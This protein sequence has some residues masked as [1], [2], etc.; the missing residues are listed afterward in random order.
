MSKRK[1]KKES[2]INN[3][4]NNSVFQKH[5]LATFSK[6]NEKF[7]M[8]LRTTFCL[9]QSGSKLTSTSAAGHAVI[10]CRLSVQAL[11]TGRD[12]RGWVWGLGKGEWGGV[13][14][15]IGVALRDGRMINS[16][17]FLQS[18]QCPA[19]SSSTVADLPNQYF[20]IVWQKKLKTDFIK[21]WDR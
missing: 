7:W 6:E 17:K 2:P 21:I 8:L 19:S 11:W 5:R 12:D 14:L 1:N 20:H 13:R 18:D 3:W 10:G 15:G 4:L 16:D 9:T